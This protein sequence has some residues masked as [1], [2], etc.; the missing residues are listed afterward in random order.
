MEIHFSAQARSEPCSAMLEKWEAEVEARL[1][2]ATHSLWDFLG[3]V[4]RMWQHSR[5]AVRPAVNV[6]TGQRCL[7]MEIHFLAQAR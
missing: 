4:E 2:I 1:Q 7:E 3:S 5:G 6:I